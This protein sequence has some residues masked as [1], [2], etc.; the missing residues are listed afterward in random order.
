M[1]RLL[2]VVADRARTPRELLGAELDPFRSMSKV[3]CDGWG[4]AF[5]NESDQLRLTKAP[6]PALGSR[7]FDELCDTART[8]A[9]LL[10]LRKASPGMSNLAENTH[11]F[12]AGGVAFAHNGW[13]WPNDE[14]DGLLTDAG[15]DAPVGSTDSERYFRLVLALARE[16]D[17]LQALDEATSQIA[18]RTEFLSL[19]CLLLTHDALYAVEYWDPPRVAA[20]GDDPDTF[21]L[22]YRVDTHAVVV[23]SSGWEQQS[24]EWT[25]LTNR[26]VLEVRRGDLRTRVHQLRATAAA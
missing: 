4:C 16:G 1:C 10:H 6:E 23:A 14:L 9:T 24:P 22:R 11:P 20:K 26:R 18:E 25:A 21:A 19:N 15:G 5:W 3:H 7:T 13:A 12:L 2:G 17:V 8:D